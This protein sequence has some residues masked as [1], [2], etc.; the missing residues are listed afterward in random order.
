MMLN[1]LFSTVLIAGSLSLGGITLWRTLIPA[2]ASDLILVNP[3]SDSKLFYT[4]KGQK[5]PLDVRS[6]VIAVSFK[7]VGGTRGE[8][9][10]LYLQ[11]QQ[12]LQPGTRGIDSGVDVEPL[13]ESYA[14][15]KFPTTRGMSNTVEQQAQKQPFV[16]ETLPVLTRSDRQETIILPNEIVLSFQPGLSEAQKTAILQ[17]NKLDVIRPLRFSR[18]LVL[19]KSTTASGVEVLTVANQLNQVKGVRSASPNFI[20]S[21]SKRQRQKVLKSAD[22]SPELQ[23]FAWINQSQPNSR[24]ISP[25]S[26]FLDLQWHLYSPPLKQCLQAKE[27]LES[28][29]RTGRKESASLPRTDLRVKEAWKQSNGG[30]G[31]VV[32]VLDSLIQWDHPNL[33]S[34]LYTVTNDNKCPGETYGWDFTIPVQTRTTDP[35]KVGDADTRISAS[36]LAIVTPHFRRTFQLSDAD[37]IQT[38]GG[39]AR[40]ILRENPKLSK[41]QLAAIMRRYIRGEIASAFHGTQVSS[42]IAAQPQAGKGVVG[43]APNAKILPVRV[44]GL[45]GQLIPANYLEALAY[46]ANRGADIIN[47]SLGAT[48]P[49]SA[50]EELITDLLQQYPN[51]VIVASTGNENN[52]EVAFPSGYSGVVAVG[53]TNLLGNRA[54]YSNFGRG[55]TL[56]APGGDMSNTWEGGILTAGGTWL[57]E[58]WQGLTIPTRRWSPVLDPKGEYWWVEGTSFSS[59]AIA[60]VIALMKGEDPQRQLNRDRLVSILKSSAAYDGLTL[61]KDET[62]FYNQQLRRRE[63]TS[64][65]S[66]QQ[67]FFGSG[68]PNADTALQEVKRSLK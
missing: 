57:P 36:E 29:L 18:D 11:L 32:A 60:G 58:F 12:A 59:P 27:S 64:S 33:K 5:I 17:Q 45:N 34:S 6:D 44:F 68:L 15:V 16:Q 43:V 49:S 53:A 42:V 25:E 37:L 22:P 48:L 50:E 2:I 62:N 66:P 39:L 19:V 10:P 3:A 38:Y 46:A 30:K 1:R 24:A 26:A 40:D 7:P 65:V 9:Q 20:Q 4:Y 56:V 52:L 13:G 8:M 47:L 21:I 55:L 63:I 61:S 67:Y 23:S 28:C 31:V 51:L 41:I 54:P 35:C 14:I